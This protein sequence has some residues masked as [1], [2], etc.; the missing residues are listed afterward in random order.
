MY[1]LPGC[2][3]DRETWEPS[4]P[5]WKEPSALTGG[6]KS[7]VFFLC[8]HEQKGRRDSGCC[9]V[10]NL[11]DSLMERFP[12]QGV[13]PLGLAKYHCRGSSGLSERMK[14][15]ATYCPML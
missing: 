10:K 2:Q 9:G 11:L 15:N 8:L 12:K 6:V 13:R 4:G 14:R 3:V 5:R 1:S 7:V